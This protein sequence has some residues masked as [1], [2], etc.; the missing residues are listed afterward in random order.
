MTDPSCAKDNYIMKS[1]F[2]NKDAENKLPITKLAV[3]LTFPTETIRSTFTDVARKLGFYI[4]DSGIDYSMAVHKPG[5]SLRR[6]LCCCPRLFGPEKMTAIKVLYEVNK[7]H[8]K[9]VI[10]VIGLSGVLFT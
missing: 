1:T 9:K 2:A 3:T 7:P 8:N 10:T 6:I 4:I 5:F